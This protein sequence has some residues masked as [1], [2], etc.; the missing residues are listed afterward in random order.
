MYKKCKWLHEWLVYFRWN[1]NFNHVIPFITVCTV[2]I[3]NK[4]ELETSWSN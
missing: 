1:L 2:E 3:K 4:T